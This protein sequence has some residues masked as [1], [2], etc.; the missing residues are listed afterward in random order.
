MVITVFHLQASR[1]RRR[2]YPAY[3]APYIEIVFFPTVTISWKIFIYNK[4]LRHLIPFAWEMERIIVGS[5]TQRSI[6][7]NREMLTGSDC[8]KCAGLILC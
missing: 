1:K 8:A 3:P 6:C 2:P 5:G 4:V 7:S